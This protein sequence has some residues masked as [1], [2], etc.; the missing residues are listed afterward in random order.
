MTFAKKTLI[1]NATIKN[2]APPPLNVDVS[3]IKRDF[4]LLGK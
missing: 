3:E 2:S 1:N 4:G